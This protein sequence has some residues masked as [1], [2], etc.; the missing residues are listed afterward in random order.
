MENTTLDTSSDPVELNP[1]CYDFHE[2]PYPVYKR[3]R[4]EAPVYHNSELE[5]WALSRYEDVAAALRDMKRLSNHMGVSLDPAAYNEHAHLVMSFLAMDDPRHAHLRRLVNKGFTSRR[6]V[7][8]HE[9]IEE[10]GQ[11]YWDECLAKGTF[12]FVDDFAGKLPMDVISELMGVPQE[13]RAELRRLADL[14]VHRE[15][16]NNDV[17]QESIEASFTLIK[18]YTDMVALRRENPTDDL[19]SALI[20]AEVE[21]EKL[22]EGEIVGFMFLMVIAGNETTTKLL[23]NAVYWID[24]NPE[25]Y[26][27]IAENPDL[28]DGWVEETLRYDTS[29][30]LLVRTVME[31]VEFHGTTIPKGDK[32]VVSLGSANRDPNYF[33]DPD[34]FDIERE[35][36]EMLM[37]FGVGG[38]FCL[39]AHLARL[40]AQIALRMIANSVQSFTLDA[41]GSERVHSSNVRGF[42]HLPM[43]VKVK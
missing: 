7:Q 36:S 10:I 2:D 26:A 38:H 15:E 13:D 1:Y 11:E 41:E 35:N 8:L 17:P 5:F 19:T 21:G 33:P 27:M 29:T 31:D 39:G 42:A 32:L 43:T 22:D 28:V 16:G 14:V 30:Q 6:I 3:L 24:K 20:A 18:Y 12:D 4:E 23:A 34:R 25:Q 9:R 37:S 40:E